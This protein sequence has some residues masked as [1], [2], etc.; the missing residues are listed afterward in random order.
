MRRGGR[1]GIVCVLQVTVAKRLFLSPRSSTAHPAQTRG[2]LGP[3]PAEGPWLRWPRCVDGSLYIGVTTDLASREE[4]HN[5]GFGSVFSARIVISRA[6]R[7]PESGPRAARRMGAAI[8]LGDDLDILVTVVPIDVV[9]DAQVGEMD[10]LI[11]VREVVVAAAGPL[12]DLAS[13]AV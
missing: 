8:V 4:L 2:G 5:Q 9:L 11:E 7:S 6:S 1:L 10:R 12:L 13:V 3:T